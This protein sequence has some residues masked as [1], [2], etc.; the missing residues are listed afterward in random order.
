M[1]SIKLFFLLGII[2]FFSPACKKGGPWG[3]RGEGSNTTEVRNLSG[4]DKIHLSIDADVFYTQDSLFKV[5]ISAQP[6][7][8]AVLKSEVNGTELTFDY[9]R[10]VWDHN[11]VKITV[12]SPNI[13]SFSISGSGNI[14]AQ[15]SL[16]S[17]SFDM[18]ISGSGNVYIP[19]ISTSDISG[20]ISGSGDVTISGGTVTN[21]S[22]NVSGSG[23]IDTENMVSESSVVK[24]S[25]SGNAIVNVSENL[26]ASIS[27]SGN[28]S[29]KGKASVQSHLSGSGRLIHLN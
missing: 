10:N 14:T 26:D 16:T 1:K 8:L 17:N 13:K 23:N 6:N 15:N 25:G 2:C 28:V 12:H 11:K 5:E 18:S 9:R 29:Y 24:V 7:I 22:F 19:S 21:E 20:T 3:I 4:F 27:G